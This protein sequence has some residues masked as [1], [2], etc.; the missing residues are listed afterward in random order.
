MPTIERDGAVIEYETRGTSGDVV[1]F[2]HNLLT[3]RAIFARTMEKLDARFRTVAVDLRAHGGSVA[4][5]EF[6]TRDLADDLVAVLDAIGATKATLVGV[7]LG[8]TAA[9][10]VALAHPDRVERLALLGATAR[11]ATTADAI[12]SRGL[13]IAARTLGMRAALVKKIAE[14]L[15][16]PTFRRDEPARLAEW[17]ARIAAMPGRDVAYA[18]RAWATRALL[19][20]RIAAIRAPT[21]LLVGNDDAPHPR[22][23]SDEIAALIHGARVE[24]IAGSGH[25]APLERPDETIAHLEAFLP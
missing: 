23:H 14:T 24:T 10:E 18:T 4:S 7:S 15:F 6:S 17:T 9:M 19:L 22:A 2:A 8:A 20:D 21:L 3:S 1:L 25:T 12:A 16:G 11:K 13:G 5:R